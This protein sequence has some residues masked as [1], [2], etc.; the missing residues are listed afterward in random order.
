MAQF[1]NLRSTVTWA[2]PLLANQPLAVNGLDPGLTWGNIVLSRILGPPFRWR[3]NRGNLS[4]AVSDSGGVDYTISVPDLGRIENAWIKN[5]SGGITGL[6]GEVEMMPVS[7]SGRPTKIAPVY[8][9]GDGNIT[10]RLNQVPDADYT[11]FSDYQRKATLF[12]SYTQPWGVVPDEF[13]YIFNQGFLT[14]ALGITRDARFPIFEQYFVS[15]LLGAQDGLDEQAINIFMGEFVRSISGVQRA[16]GMTQS[17]VA[18][19]QK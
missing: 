5:S 14:Y 19:R 3:F 11:V 18:A 1:L 9:D 7:E 13:N 2:L 4:F 15:A 8:D 6:D 16:Q 12:T 17:G 10:F